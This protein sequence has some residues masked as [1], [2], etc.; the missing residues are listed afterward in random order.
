MNRAAETAV[1]REM[2]C[3]NVT[4]RRVCCVDDGAGECRYVTQWTD[5]REH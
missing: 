1:Y 4:S 5:R 2:G 3:L